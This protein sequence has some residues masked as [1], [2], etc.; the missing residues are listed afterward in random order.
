VR[1]VQRRMQVLQIDN[2]PEYIDRLRQEPDQL[3]LLFRDLLIGVTQFFR[4]PEAFAALESEVIPKLLENKRNDDQI[5]IWVPGCATGE[6]AYSIA[7]LVK[8]A[9]VNLE[10]APKVQIFATDLDEHAVTIARHERYRQTL[11]GVSP[12]RLER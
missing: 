2:V 12:E 10:V 4:D 8:E 7:I 1:R 6:E 3:D 9:M 11:S 5:R